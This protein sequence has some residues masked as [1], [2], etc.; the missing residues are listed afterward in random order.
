MSRQAVIMIVIAIIIIGGG[1]LLFVNEEPTDRSNGG[2]T[3][4]PG[5]VGELV[6]EDTYQTGNPDAKV[7]IVEFAD[8]Q[9]PACATAFPAVK[10]VRQ[11]YS[12]DELK[13]V[14]R[15]FPLNIHKNG[16][17][18][19]LAAEAAREQGKFEEMA[20]LLFARQSQW[21]T[22]GNPINVFLDF[23]RELELDTEQFRQAVETKK[24][25]DLVFLG[26]QDGYALNVNS[27]PTFFIN[28]EPYRQGLSLDEFQKI[29]NQML[30]L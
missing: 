13:I 8:L 21:N 17:V 5:H 23:A 22:V 24:Y 26:M 19:S 3:V 20:E 14:F 16:Q 15:H 9:C 27:T 29:I 12:A 28:G 10:A 7:T 6:R 25:E 1:I 18:A 4:D 2:F 30:A 11:L